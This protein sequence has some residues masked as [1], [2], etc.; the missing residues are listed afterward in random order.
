MRSANWFFEP[1]NLAALD[2]WR[3]LLWPWVA[4]LFFGAC[5]YLIGTI[6]RDAART[7]KAFSEPDRPSRPAM[8]PPPTATADAASAYAASRPLPPLD[9][10]DPCADHLWRGDERTLSGLHQAFQDSLARTYGGKQAL[11]VAVAGV[12]YWCYSTFDSHNG[13][14]HGQ[15]FVWWHAPAAFAIVLYVPFIVLNYYVFAWMIP[16]HIVAIYLYRSLQKSFPLR[17]RPYLPD[18]CNGTSPFGEHIVTLVYM[19][20]AIAACIFLLIVMPVFSG[21]DANFK[22]DTLFYFIAYPPILAMVVIPISCFVHGP[23]SRGKTALLNE[24]DQLIQRRMDLRRGQG[25][26]PDARKGA[27][28]LTEEIGALRAEHQAI[29]SDLF[30]WPYSKKTRRGLSVSVVFPYVAPVLSFLSRY[31]SFGPAPPSP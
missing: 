27:R 1:L 7:A 15:D 13:S 30:T 25:T 31:L 11:F 18:R 10:L 21:N 12:A 5:A 3:E 23:L 16:W 24:L 28:K 6:R 20:A 26:D 4:I 9:A 14:L 8:A 17:S 2:P 19:L 29:E 22:P